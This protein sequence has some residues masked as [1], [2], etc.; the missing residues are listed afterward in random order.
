MIS[1][2]FEGRRKTI[3][4]CFEEFTNEIIVLC[5]SSKQIDWNFVV[6]FH[7]CTCLEYRLPDSSMKDY[8]FT[9]FTWKTGSFYF[10]LS[11]DENKKF[12]STKE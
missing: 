11:A 4:S 12:P 1:F 3:A 5:L 8:N 2:H 10:Q 7:P 6:F 9:H